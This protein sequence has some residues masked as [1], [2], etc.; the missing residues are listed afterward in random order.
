MDNKLLLVKSC[1]LLYRE[2]LITGKTENSS[3]IVRTVLE[4]IKLADVNIDIN[5]DRDILVALKHTTIEMC[6]NPIDH[7]YE[8]DELLQRLK[9]N[10]GDDE[11]LYDA[12]FQGIDPELSET[13]LK[14]TVVN[15]RKSIHNHFREQKVD[16]ILSKA[17]MQ[18]K[19]HREK[20][21]NVNQFVAELCGQLEPFQFDASKL[22]PAIISDIDTSN[23]DDVKNVFET[24]KSE[25]DGR[26][27]LKTGWQGINRMLNGGFRRG[28]EWVIGA[29][30]HKYKTGFSLSLFKQIA[31]YNVP[32][33]L[34]PTKKPLLLRISFEDAL[35]LNFQFLYQTLKEQETGEKAEIHGI[36]TDEM[37]EYVTKRLSVNGYHTRFMHVNP[38]LWTYKDICNKILELED[39]GYE[40]HMCM[41]DYLIK[42]PTTGCDIGPMG[43]DIRNLYE[44]IRNFMSS[45]KI[46]F[47]TPHQLS[48]DA[49]V[50]IRD[51]RNEFVKELTGRGYYS[52]TKQ[53]DQVVDGELFIHIEILNK[54]SYLTVQ[55]GKHRIIEQTPVEHQYCVLKFHS[56][57][58][59]PDDFGKAD[60][61]RKKVGGGHIGSVDETPFFSFENQT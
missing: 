38:S 36:G 46:L 8:K 30:Q 34:N 6:D 56:I 9:M 61:T 28:E 51:G 59:I 7:E 27:I 26:S 1:T 32:V 52:G 43:H 48:T 40:V 20:I 58:G 44:R 60:T 11:K 50:L 24:V 31:L 18:F 3:D 33:M 42:L 14:R 12:F 45:R 19:F 29:L 17:S 39:E 22:D 10:S 25:T 4:N 41:V 15:I 55:R 37:A 49:K 5:S 2:S 35:T 47:I 13:S 21:K 16:E 23:L 53:L 57:G 54:E